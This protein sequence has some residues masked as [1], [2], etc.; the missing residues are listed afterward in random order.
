MVLLSL[1][2]INELSKDSTF[3]KENNIHQVISPNISDYCNFYIDLD[4]LELIS[5]E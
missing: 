5:K 1:D 3:Y 4:H 2:E